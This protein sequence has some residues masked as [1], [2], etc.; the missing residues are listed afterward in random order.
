MHRLPQGLHVSIAPDGRRAWAG[1][2]VLAFPLLSLVTPFGIGLAG[3]L[4]AATALAW[5]HDSWRQLRAGWPRTRWVLLAFLLQLLDVAWLAASRGHG[6]KDLDAPV[7]M[8]MAVAAMLV[9]QAAAPGARALWLGAAGGALAGLAFVA[10]QRL[11]LG[12]ERPGGLMNPITFGDLSLCLAWLALGGL[13][14][15]RTADDRHGRL[16]RRAW[17]GIAGGGV[18][19]GLA[20]SLLTGSRGGWLALLLLLFLLLGRLLA[21]LPARLLADLLGQPRA[22][23]SLL[24]RRLALALP[25]TACALAAAAWGIPQTG[26][27][28]RVAIGVNDARLY[29]EGNPA[30]TSLSVRLALWQAGAM[31]V[32]ER[33]WA[34]RDTPAYKQRMREWVARGRLTPAVFAP[35]EPPH[36]HN[37]ALQMLVTRGVTGLLAWCGILVAPAC[38]FAGQL[39]AGAPGAPGRT[40]GHTAALIGLVFVLAY[41]GFGLTEVIFWSMKASLFYALMV[42]LL[43]AYCLTGQQTDPPAPPAAGR[44][45]PDTAPA[46]PGSRRRWPAKG[47]AR[48]HGAGGR[49]RRARVLRRSRG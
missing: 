45:L 18:L 13:A 4:F 48:R 38:F 31:L 3:F 7:R 24:P 33:P 35:P 16:R 41:A 30:A 1:A 36:L 39:R 27:R 2:L 28:D 23:R 37:D 46:D 14:G 11:A 22:G 25:L 10:W 42:F 8:C 34:G 15:T 19:C 9:V 43:M 29:L 44:A 32:R 6:I 21:R 12:V 17:Q 49:R 5:R 26:V 20:A 47:S 40:S